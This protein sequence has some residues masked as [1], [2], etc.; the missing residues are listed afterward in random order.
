MTRPLRLQYEGAV[1]HITSRG[2]GRQK[3]YFNDAD[4]K[5]FLLVLAETLSRYSWNCHAYCLMS[6][7]YHLLIETRE[8]SLSQ[9]MRH[10]NGVYTQSF[11][12][13]HSRVGHL[14]QGR[15][16]A[17]HV[18]K[19]AHSLELCR[20][21]VLNPVR[22]KMVERPEQYR[23]SSYRGTLKPQ[24][25]LGWMDGKWILEQFGN[26]RRESVKRYKEFVREGIG[27]KESPW[28]KLTGQIYYGS[29]AFIRKHKIN[30][31]Q[32]EI[33][34]AHKRPLRKGL[35]EIFKQGGTAAEID[36]GVKEGY[37][38]VEVARHL[39]VHYTTVSMRVRRHREK[40]N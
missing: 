33:P 37:K 25:R 14:F 38:M 5:K 28:E 8:A 22:A 2:N 26:N 36:E 20:Y 40:Q 1:Y 39:G 16:K 12:H 6:N 35:A 32:R 11:N 4:R 34:Q 10:L 24:H 7:H 23:W 21:V 3:I 13:E 27:L 18:E 17:I 30:E 29:E 9:G 15:Y 31:R 19:G